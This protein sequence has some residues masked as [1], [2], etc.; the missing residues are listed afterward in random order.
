[1]EKLIPRVCYL[2][3]SYHPAQGTIKFVP[4]R[5]VHGEYLNTD[6]IDDDYSRQE[7]ETDVSESVIGIPKIRG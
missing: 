7:S 4:I 5:D 6:I 2:L 1:M 3:K